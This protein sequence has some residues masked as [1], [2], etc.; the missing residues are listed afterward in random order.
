MPLTAAERDAMIERYAHG[1]ALL[2][3][4]LAKVPGEALRWKPAAGRWSAHEIVIHCADSE[5]NAHMRLRY[6]LAEPDP[7][8]VGY[9]QDRWATTFDYHAHPLE[10]ALATVEAVRANTVPLLR[11]LAERDWRRVGRHTESGTYAVEDWLAIYAE[12]LEKHSRQIER[13]L[14]TWSAR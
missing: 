4:A 2:K 7:L 10:P 9:D 14:D 5:T 6:L 1:P 11:R 3:R 12:H 13:N 8:I